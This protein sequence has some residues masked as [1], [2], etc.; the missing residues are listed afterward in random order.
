MVGIKSTGWG[1]TVHYSP[2]K[3]GDEQEHGADVPG[4]GPDVH[5]AGGLYPKARFKTKHAE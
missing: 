4:S 5:C 1:Q 3:S 2:G